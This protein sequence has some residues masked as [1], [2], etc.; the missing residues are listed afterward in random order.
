MPT[1]R[2]LYGMIWL[3]F[4]TLLLACFDGI[5]FHAAAH[6]VLGMAVLAL[7][8]HNQKLLAATACPD[9]IKRISAAMVAVSV[10]GALSGVPLMLPLPAWLGAILKFLHLTAICALFTQS[11]SVATA[12]D[13]WEQ[14]EFLPEG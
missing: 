11:A 6:S 12:H 4:F 13:M 1:W 2:K 14:K 7:A 10:L 9:R 8:V 5:P 3:N